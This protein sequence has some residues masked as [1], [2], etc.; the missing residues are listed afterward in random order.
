MS[1]LV[2]VELVVEAFKVEKLP[3]VPHRVVMVAKVE[4]KVLM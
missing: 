4:V 2:V 3:V 1:A